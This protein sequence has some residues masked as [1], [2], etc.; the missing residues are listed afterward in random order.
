MTKI[1]SGTVRSADGTTIAF[2]RSGTGSAVIFVHGALTDRTFPVLGGLAAALAPRLTVFNYDRRGRGGSGDTMPYAV[3]R[4]IEDIDA[5][6]R[7]AG[8]SAMLFGGS[9]GAALAL[10]AAAA[11][12]LVSKLA[13]WEPPYHVDP[14]APQLP[15]DFRGQLDEL[16]RAR[17]RTKLGHDSVSLHESRQDDH[18]T[19][20]SAQASARSL[21]SDSDGRESAA[22]RSRTERRWWRSPRSASSPLRPWGW[23][24][25]GRTGPATRRSGRPP[26]CPPAAAW[27][28]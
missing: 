16:V 7:E 13:L 27:A 28:W 22:G 21:R 4:E 15:G 6:I 1:T 5:L 12:L 14:A 26:R 20:R 24:P 3:Q 19:G 17:I 8:G 18:G 23:R 2:D 11:G 25:S 10:E 9:S